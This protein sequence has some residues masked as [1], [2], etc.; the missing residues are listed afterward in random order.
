MSSADFLDTDA[1][2]GGGKESFKTPEPALQPTTAL[3]KLT[4]KST[5]PLYF[6]EKK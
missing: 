3:K 5:N 4:I 1:E 6:F 2:D